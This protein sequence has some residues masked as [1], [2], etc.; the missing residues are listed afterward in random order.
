M[1]AGSETPES[2]PAGDW[3]EEVETPGDV[4]DR[5][6]EGDWSGDPPSGISGPFWQE[7]GKRKMEGRDAKVLVTAKDGQTGVGKSNFCDF[8]SYVSDT[9]P[10]GFVPRKTTIEPQRFIELY[11][12]LPKGSAL[13]MEEAEQFD[14][15]RGMT[16][17]NVEGTQTW[18]QARVREIIAWLNLPDPSMIDTRFEKL[19][20]FWVNVERRGKARVY[21]K[22]IHSTKQV[23]YYK[24][25][26]TIE[27]P[28][29]DGSATFER[30]DDLKADMLDGELGND[31]LIRESEAQER[32]D[33]AVTEAQQDVRDAWIVALKEQGWTG[34]EIAAL[35]TVDVKGARVNQIARGE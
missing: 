28:N 24:T 25:M 29:M 11:H 34:K 13:V 27:W 21:E 23:V 32:I 5:I 20:D 7:L 12:V 14:S 33:Q 16:E 10:E 30:M 2:V 18:Q 31:G 19:A 35:P 26:Q 1:S 8:A 17:E 22:K 4:T 6:E 9:T 15:R 3:D